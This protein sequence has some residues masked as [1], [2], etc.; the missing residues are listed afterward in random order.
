MKIL[1]LTDRSAVLGR[2]EN[3][4]YTK[5]GKF[6]L[7]RL[8]CIVGFHRISQT[9]LNIPLLLVDEKGVSLLHKPLKPLP[10]EKE[11]S[12]I[13][14]RNLRITQNIVH[15]FGHYARNIRTLLELLKIQPLLYHT[16]LALLSLYSG[17]AHTFGSTLNLKTSLMGEEIT[18][19]EIFL[20]PPTAYAVLSELE[21]VLKENLP[22]YR[23][24]RE[25]V[26]LFLSYLLTK[27]EFMTLLGKSLLRDQSHLSEAHGGLPAHTRKLP[28]MEKSSEPPLD[29]II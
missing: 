21:D 29:L 17:L 6:K 27:R 13:A 1:I 10:E 7:S 20:L 11:L 24:P 3:Y 4:I 26:N 23:E 18:A 8:S 25:C 14:M 22:P 28:E 15:K 5:R 2:N 16:F 19:F 12:K 9:P